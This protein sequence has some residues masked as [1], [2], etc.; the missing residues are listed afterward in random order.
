MSAAVP[1]R[2]SAG[3]WIPWLFVAFFLLVVAVNGT[4]I[5]VALTSWTG[6]AANQPYDKG[7]TY[8]RNLDAAARQ[9]ALGWRPTL[10]VRL[11]GG[12][13]KV[14]LLLTDAKGDAVDGAQ[15]TVRFERPTSE[16]M[17]FAVE[18]QPAGAGAYRAEFA[19]PAAGAWNLHAIVRRG[20][21]LHVHDQRVVL[22]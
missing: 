7:L 3:T 6:L 16:G 17:D 8:N 5:W 14:E 18:L 15:A 21:D 10:S 1:A 4:M 20:A 22:P 13:G 12:T 19:P 11:D 9:A 2:R